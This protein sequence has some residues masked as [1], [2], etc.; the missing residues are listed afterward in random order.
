MPDE[1][2]LHVT[3]P[4]RR[5]YK[6]TIRTVAITF[7]CCECGREVTEEQYP[8][9]APKW[10]YDCRRE[11]KRRQQRERARRYRQRQRDHR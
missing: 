2:E 5:A 9:A 4:R 8:G 7:V 10:C 6:R 11:V 1:R 3:D